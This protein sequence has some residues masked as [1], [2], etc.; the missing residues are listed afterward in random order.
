MT[1][2]MTMTEN[3]IS[4][5]RYISLPVFTSKCN[6][7]SGSLY[8]AFEKGVRCRGRS[9]APNIVPIFKRFWA[10][11]LKMKTWENSE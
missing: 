8:C 3:A 6:E 9:E 5:P 7:M 11:N 1:I 4:Q 2:K 10:T